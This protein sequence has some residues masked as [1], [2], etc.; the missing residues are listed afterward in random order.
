MPLYEHRCDACA[1][2][3]EQYAPLRAAP[4]AIVCPA[5]G[6]PAPQII[7]RPAAVAPEITPYFD[8]GLDARVTSRAQ[9]RTLMRENG[10]VEKG[11][12]A[13]HGTKGTIF[14]HPGQTA[15]SV[16][17]SGAYARE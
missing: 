15:A 9:R 14:S 3:T 13:L 1:L 10:L 17:K 5:C 12:T 4:L 7:S 11:T 6:G 8:R 16:P 2:V